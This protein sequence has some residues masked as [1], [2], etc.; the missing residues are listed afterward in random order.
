MAPRW[1]RSAVVAGLASFTVTLWGCGKEPVPE[2]PVA[3]APAQ[4]TSANATAPAPAA[5]A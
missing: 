1:V 3:E 5:E 2:A 4:A